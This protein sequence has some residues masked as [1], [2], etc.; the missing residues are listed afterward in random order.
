MNNTSNTLCWAWHFLLLMG[1]DRLSLQ[2]FPNPKVFAIWGRNAFLFQQFHHG[3]FLWVLLNWAI[4]IAY[5]VL[6][7]FFTCFL[8]RGAILISTKVSFAS[9][10][11]CVVNNTWTCL[12]TN[13]LCKWN[14]LPSCLSEKWTLRWWKRINFE[15][16]MRI[17][18]KSFFISLSRISLNKASEGFIRLNGTLQFAEKQTALYRRVNSTGLVLWLRHCIGLKERWVLRQLPR[19]IIKWQIWRTGWTGGAFGKPP[20]SFPH[21]VVRLNSPSMTSVII[22]KTIPPPLSQ[23]QVFWYPTYSPKC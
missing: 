7:Y 13:V 22:R 9:Y 5:V 3:Y 20:S 18:R 11:M 15:I 6:S 16:W 23:S 17:C 8:T 19:F 14:L 12:A 10:L 1:S 4:D 2:P 21:S